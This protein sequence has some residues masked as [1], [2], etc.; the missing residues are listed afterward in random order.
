MDALYQRDFDDDYGSVS[1]SGGP[2]VWP[3]KLVTAEGVIVLLCIYFATVPACQRHLG[4]T[5]HR[6]K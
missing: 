6:D 5:Q 3:W 1:M 4:T 2:T